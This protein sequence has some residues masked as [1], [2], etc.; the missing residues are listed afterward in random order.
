MSTTSTVTSTPAKL[1]E[2]RDEETL[3]LL[4]SATHRGW[5][6][7]DDEVALG[8]VEPAVE[9]LSSGWG[10]LPTPERVFCELLGREPT[11]GQLD[12]AYVDVL[13]TAW[14]AGYNLRFALPGSGL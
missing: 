14:L 3:A 1:A 9:P 7:A 8:A 4:D 5:Q 12:R 13:A 6:Y 11:S 2:L 10:G